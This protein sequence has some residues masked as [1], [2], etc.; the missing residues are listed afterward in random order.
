MSDTEAPDLDVPAID[1]PGDI[2][3]P[4]GDAAGDEAPGY[5][6]TIS[7][8]TRLLFKQAAETTKAQLEDG[9]VDD[10]V[11]A[12]DNPNEPSV[13]AAPAGRSPLAVPT[14]ADP[15]AADPVSQS[16]AAAA[17]TSDPHKALELEVREKAIA[18]REAKLAE[19]EKASTSIESLGERYLEKPSD[20]LRELLKQWTGA[21]TDEALKDE[22]ADLVTD[23]S[24]NVLGLPVSRE[25]RDRTEARRAIRTVK[26]YKTSEQRREAERAK[27]DEEQRAQ[28]EQEQRERLA[29]DAIGTQLKATSAK[30]AH[31][32]AEDSPHAI[33]WD[34]IKTKA[35]RD[36]SWQP[37]WEEAAQL[38]NE[39]FKNLHTKQHQKLTRLFTP[40]AQAPA[41]EAQ[42]QGAAQGRAARTL[43]N[44]STAPQPPSQPAPTSPSDDDAPYDKG[45]AR[46][47]SLAKLRAGLQSRTT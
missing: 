33:V 35:S 25:V 10:L 44:A 8:N 43:T 19:R 41:V 46:A 21:D 24:A 34:V 15:R 36:P 6:R 9:G 20:I 47:R 1:A 11:P 18:E 37:N 17:P 30:Y 3:G 13:A 23:L 7:E 28:V 42:H 5:R 26:A 12:I 40:S 38:A 27:R 32:M 29:M 14:D 45:R 16:V 39:H 22:V 4:V 31:L 2:G